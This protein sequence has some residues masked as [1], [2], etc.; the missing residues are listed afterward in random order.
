MVSPLSARFL[1]VALVMTS[2]GCANLTVGNVFS[3]QPLL[4]THS[5]ESDQPPPSPAPA[6]YIPA[7]RV[8]AAKNPTHSSSTN[9][10]AKVI[11]AAALPP[12]TAPQAKVDTAPA[13][14]GKADAAIRTLYERAAKS[15]GTI[16]SY[17]LRLRRREVIGNRK[18]PEEIILFKMRMEPRSLY[19]K[20]LGKEGFHRQDIYNFSDKII[21][22]L[23]A[24]GDIPFIPA[25]QHMKLAPDSLL[26]K[27]NSRHPV[28][29]AGL[30]IIVNRLGDVLAR[31][32]KGDVKAGELKYLGVL[33]R[34]EFDQPVE[35]VM[36]VIP[37]GVEKLLPKG[38]QRLLFFDSKT[39]LPVLVITHDHN[40]QEVEYYCYDRIQFPVAL[41]N[42][43]FDPQLLWGK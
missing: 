15:T 26:I 3:G 10:D 27:S 38:G 6:L 25:G 31:W 43:D 7:K 21:K 35:A 29:E 30:D 40:G 42:R 19:M 12:M 13:A 11:Q 18:R 33:K 4:L 20:W 41:D 8:S 34:P 14:R 9:K 17:I 16:K 36:H 39:D 32:E 24:A 23:T 1:I 22:V 37:P 2:C 5:E 28:T